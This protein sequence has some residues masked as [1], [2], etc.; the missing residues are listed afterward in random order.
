MNGASLRALQE[1]VKPVA[2]T[3]SLTLEQGSRAVSLNREIA[4][5]HAALSQARRILGL[6]GVIDERLEREI[7]ARAAQ[8]V[9]AREDLEAE[10]LAGGAEARA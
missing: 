7:L 5:F 8:L 4:R 3:G 2:I 9:R 6:A 10:L 1:A